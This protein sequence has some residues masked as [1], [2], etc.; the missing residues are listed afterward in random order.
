MRLLIVEDYPALRVSLTQGLQSEGYAVDAAEDGDEGWWY[1]KDTPYDAVILDRMLPGMDGIEILKKMRENNNDTPVLLLTA[2]DSVEDRVDGLDAGADDYLTKP[3][4]VPEL[5]A[6][7]RRLV[8]RRYDK[9]SNVLALDDL[10]LDTVTHR[11]SRNAENIALSPREFHLLEYLLQ[12]QSE[13]VSR[14]ELWDHLYD[15]N[16]DTSSNVLDVLIARLRKKLHTY[17]TARVLI[18][19]RRG[20]GFVLE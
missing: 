20:Q 6:R 13:I 15:F 17:E 1:L 19:T 9:T 18:H 3:F 7:L 14:S 11:V 16:S 5:L 8:R 4:A 12:R 10:S 2:R